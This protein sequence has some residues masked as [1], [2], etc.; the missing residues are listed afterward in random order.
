VFRIDLAGERRGEHIMLRSF[1]NP[2]PFW[3]LDNL[4]TADATAEVH[5]T[6]FAPDWFTYDE[7]TQR[8]S[9]CNKWGEFGPAVTE[10]VKH[11]I[12][13]AA[14]LR[15]YDRLGLAGQGLRPDTSIYS[16]GVNVMRPGDFLQPHIDHCLHPK[17]VPPMEHKLNYVVF[18]VPE[19]R[20]EWGGALQFYDELCGQVSARVFPSPGR[21]VAWCTDEA[22]FHAVDKIADD[23]PVPRF[24]VSAFHYAP[25]TL[26]TPRIKRGLF[27]PDRGPVPV[28]PRCLV[29]PPNPCW[30]LKEVQT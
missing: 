23:C 11:L 24:T 2:F 4:D 21:A 13:P 12:D 6:G 20:E 16:S 28:S 1:D 26:G 17:L 8:K 30:Q 5:D 9:M 18:L 14:C 22:A 7:P 25:A 3:V 10:L 29:F 27:A 15:L 19:W